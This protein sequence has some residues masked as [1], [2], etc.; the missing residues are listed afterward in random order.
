MEEGIKNEDD[1][2]KEITSQNEYE[3]V[4]H[5]DITE[6]KKETILDTLEKVREECPDE[7]YPVDMEDCVNDKVYDGNEKIMR[8]KRRMKQ[9]ILKATYFVKVKK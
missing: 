7:T 5:R 8:K 3:G 1:D 4:I 9:Q 6:N 2:D